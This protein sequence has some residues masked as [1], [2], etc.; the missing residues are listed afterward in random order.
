M[1]IPR[2]K[3]NDVLNDFIDSREAAEYIGLTA[4]QL[5]NQR[6][7]DMRRMARGAYSYGP[8]WYKEKAS[9]TSRRGRIYYKKADLD[10]YLNRELVPY[11]PPTAA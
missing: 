7:A 10:D 8:I 6:S 2:K 1:D 9:A 5:D 3:A 4:A 11:T